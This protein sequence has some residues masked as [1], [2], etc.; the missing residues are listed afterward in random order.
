MIIDQ[1][2]LDYL[3][4]SQSLLEMFEQ[5]TYIY[6]YNRICG[7]YART[8]LP[9]PRNWKSQFVVHSDICWEIV[10][11]PIDVFTNIYNINQKRRLGLGI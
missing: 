1:E 2:C 11:K 5:T 9:W 7:M 10:P 6:A 8:H 3:L 4:I